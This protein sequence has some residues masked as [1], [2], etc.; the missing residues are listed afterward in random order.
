[1]TLVDNGEIDTAYEGAAGT[2]A[3]REHHH[4]VREELP[5]RALALSKSDPAIPTEFVDVA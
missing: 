5:V 2:L 1:V 3:A 4:R